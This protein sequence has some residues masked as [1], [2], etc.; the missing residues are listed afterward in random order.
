MSGKSSKVIKISSII[1]FIALI[2]MVINMIVGGQSVSE[3]Q[4]P[5]FVCLLAIAVT[6]GVIFFKKEDKD[7]SNKNE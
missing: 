1:I 7:D 3:T 4:I 6:N 5:I 2:I